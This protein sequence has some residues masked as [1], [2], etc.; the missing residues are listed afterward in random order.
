MR[1]GL[2]LF[3]VARVARLL[4]LCLFLGSGSQFVEIHDVMD[5]IH[6]GR[7]ELPA[8]LRIFVSVQPCLLNSLEPPAESVV[9]LFQDEIL[10][11]LHVASVHGLVADR[12]GRVQRA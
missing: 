4:T 11:R 2:P 7:H 3:A 8:Q 1:F 10:D 12:D 6:I 9:H 5:V